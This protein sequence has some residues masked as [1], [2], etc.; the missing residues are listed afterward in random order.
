MPSRYAI[1]REI[2]FHIVFTFAFSRRLIM[3]LQIHIIFRSWLYLTF[4][5]FMKLVAWYSY[6]VFQLYFIFRISTNLAAVH[7]ILKKQSKYTISAMIAL[8]D[9]IVSLKHSILQLFPNFKSSNINLHQIKLFTINLFDIWRLFEIFE[10][11]N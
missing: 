7:L 11:S 4:Y 9:I 6:F 1:Y 5:Y 8:Q 3:Y 2:V 10:L